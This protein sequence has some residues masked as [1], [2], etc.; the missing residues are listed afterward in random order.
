MP[1]ASFTKLARFS[2][3]C[4]AEIPRW[5]RR[6]LEGFGDDIGVD[7]RVRPRRRDADCATSLLE[8]GAPGLHFYTLNQAA[9][10]TAIWQLRSA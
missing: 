4:G 2:D 1:I 8:R 3:A 10:T 7:P 9:L 6:R 5:I